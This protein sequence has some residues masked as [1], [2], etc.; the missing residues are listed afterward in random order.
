[1]KLKIQI[2]DILTILVV[3]AFFP[4]SIMERMSSSFDNLQRYLQL[5]FIAVLLI[6]LIIN[7]KVK[8][9][10]SHFRWGLYCLYGLILTL[11]MEPEST[12][13]FL[14]RVGVP[15][16]LAVLLCLSYENKSNGIEKLLKCMNFYWTTLIFLN[17]LMMFLFPNGII[18]SSGGA[19]AER[20]NWL[21]GSKNNVVLPLI[22]ASVIFLYNWMCDSRRRFI[23]LVVF[24]AMVF[25]SLMWA[26]SNGVAAFQGSSTGLLAFVLFFFLLFCIYFLHIRS[27]INK[28]IIGWVSVGFFCISVVVILGA[29]SS[30]TFIGTLFEATGKDATASYRT[31]IWADAINRTMQSPIVGKGYTLEGLFRGSTQ[32]YNMFLDCVYRYGIVGLMLLFSAFWSYKMNKNSGCANVSSSKYVF[33]VGIISMFLCAVVNSIKLEHLIVLLELYIFLDNDSK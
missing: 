17:C 28:N 10:K 16:F 13:R 3:F 30:N 12:Y 27:L 26:G 18:R 9:S 20:A 22:F 31:F 5:F 21:L 33:L 4:P 25:Y 7:E 8:F 6:N 14:M 19:T 32:T 15:V 1:M 11:M 2:S 29:I 24:F 23:K